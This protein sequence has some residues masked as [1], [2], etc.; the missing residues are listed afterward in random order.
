[1]QYIF[2]FA[3]RKFTCMTI[4]E[5]ALSFE[6]LLE[7]KKKVTIISHFNPDGDAV[8]SSVGLNGYLLDMGYDSRIVLPSTIPPFLDFLDPEHNIIYYSE[9]KQ[10]AKATVNDCDMIV[11][12]DFNKPE[13]TE[14]MSDLLTSAKADKVMIDH[15]PNAVLE[16]FNIVISDTGASSTCEL[17]FRVLMAFRHTEGRASSLSLNSLTAIMAG[18]LTDTN[19]FNNSVTPHTFNIAAEML[20]AGVDFDFLNN[21]LFKRF[22]ESRMRLMGHLL[23][24]SMKLERNSQVSCMVLSL[25]EKKK[26]GIQDGDTEGFVNLPLMIKGVEVS[27]LFS[28][29]ED[30]IKVSLRSK[31]SFSVNAL[32]KSYFNG[33]GHERA[34]GGRLYIPIGQVRDYFSES[35][36]QFLLNNRRV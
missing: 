3:I 23:K 20:K 2:N 14:W 16:G 6:G 30:F 11:C 26:F 10:R 27:A 24:D 22:S 17:L 13:R 8:G 1:M 29:S 19:N 33:G 4:D 7:K 21:M 28:E 5:L 12:L 36:E 18:M 31:G 34:A 32:A 25:E 9:D 15:H 35:L